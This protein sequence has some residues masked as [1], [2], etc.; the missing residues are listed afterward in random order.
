MRGSEL[1]IFIGVLFLSCDLHQNGAQVKITNENLI[2]LHTMVL[3]K[4]FFFS[5][6][7]LNF[8]WKNLWMNYLLSTVGWNACLF[9]RAIKQKWKEEDE[10]KKTKLLLKKTDKI[11]E[12]EGKRNIL[13]WKYALQFVSYWIYGCF[14]TL[15]LSLS[16]FSLQS[17]WENRQRQE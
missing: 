10:E 7:K 5:F 13:I 1:W 16:L 17:L 14:F 8:I 15:A 11:W 12:N 6:T 2:M 4:F 3:T 9:K